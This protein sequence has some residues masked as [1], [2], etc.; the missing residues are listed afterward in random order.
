MEHHTS[1]SSESEKRVMQLKFFYNCS[2]WR[3]LKQNKL[4][5]QYLR[6]QNPKKRWNQRKGSDK[7]D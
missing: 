3:A 1:D 5:G 4:F 6:V 7:E 2:Q